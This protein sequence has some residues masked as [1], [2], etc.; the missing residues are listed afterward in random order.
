[1]QRRRLVGALCGLAA[2]T[3]AGISAAQQAGHA[4]AADALRAADA[5]ARA[6]GSDAVLV[7]HGGAP[8]YAFGDVTRPMNLYSARKSVLGMLFGVHAG[9]GE[10]DLQATLGALGIDDAR[11]PLTQAEKGATVQQ[12]MQARSGVYLPAAYEMAGNAAQRPE[13]GS[14][15]P[16]SFWYYN[17]WDF[18]ALAAVFRRCTGQSVFDALQADL[19]APL[20]MQDFDAAQHTR[21]PA[22]AVS[23]HPAYLMLLS[24]RDLAR[25]G[26]LMLHGG[27]WQG[28]QLL[29]ADWVARSTAALSV[30][31]PGWQAYGELWWVPRRAW[32]FWTRA[33]GD[34]FFASG[35]HGQLL[36]VD[37]ARELVVVHQIDGSRWFKR[38]A[39]LETL[40]PL[41]AALLA[42]VQV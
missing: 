20:Q 32:P 24:A 22:E 31:P 5:A 10:I 38:S 2:G 1:M 30:V 40:S 25:L 41:L 29:P 14:H 13:R 37:R 42:A 9:R 7:L 28:R 17:N 19:A 35:N 39:D 33:P 16:G 12:L 6:L 8:V 23:E 27:A 4:G 11:Q 34:L 18:N 21:W 36:L 15:A 3:A 26:L